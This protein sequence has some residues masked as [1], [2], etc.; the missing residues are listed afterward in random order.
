MDTECIQNVSS[1]KVRLELGKSNNIEIE[2]EVDNIPFKEI[3]EHLNSKAGTKYRHNSSATKSKI[4]ARWSEGFRLEDFKQVIETKCDEWCNS[5]MAKYLR[6]ETL[7]GN[8]FENYLNQQTK[9]KEQE[10]FDR[11][12]YI[13]S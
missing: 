10:T 4:K 13:E 3:I 12:L 5:D 7:F 11:S 6:P 1:G 2:K 8:K 9:P